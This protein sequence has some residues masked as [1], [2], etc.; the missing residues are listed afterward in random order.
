M[1]VDKSYGSGKSRSAANS[2]ARRRAAEGK[3]TKSKKGVVSQI[4][5]GRAKQ[6][7]SPLGQASDVAMSFFLPGGGIKGIAKMFAPKAARVAKAATRLSK[8]AKANL[9]ANRSQSDYY[10]KQTENAVS[11][12][13]S[14]KALPNPTRGELYNPVS[15]EIRARA[16]A[17]K[18]RKAADAIEQSGRLDPA[19]NADRILGRLEQ[20]KYLKKRGGR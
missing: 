20:F 6:A 9:T 4:K 14:A 16:N 10:I 19:I 2:A 17:E 8:S 18:T 11:D 15:R 1:A 13:Y 3:M 12:W 7:A 5:A